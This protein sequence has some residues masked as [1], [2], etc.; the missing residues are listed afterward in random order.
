[1]GGSLEQ[2]KTPKPCGEWGGGDLKSMVASR[3]NCHMC[4]NNSTSYAGYVLVCGFVSCLCV[5]V[6]AVIIHSKLG[7]QCVSNNIRI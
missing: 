2:A 1:M 7:Q 4:K 3:Q 5:L 6:F